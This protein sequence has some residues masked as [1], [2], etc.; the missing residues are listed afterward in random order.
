MKVKCDNCGWEAEIADD[1]ESFG[2][3]TVH[4]LYERLTV[5]GT[6]PAGQCRECGAL[7]YKVPPK[8][9]RIDIALCE[10]EWRDITCDGIERKSRLH[11]VVVIG[12]V[13]H[14]LE[15]WR[16]EEEPSNALWDNCGEEVLDFIRERANDSDIRRV[17]I[18]GKEYVIWM[19]P[20]VD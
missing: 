1:D 8:V 16:I 3:H 4:H 15:A 7:C 5:S 14:H 9:N 10:V 19:Y 18:D 2:L 12:G 13:S 20:F 11:A 17:T 6:V